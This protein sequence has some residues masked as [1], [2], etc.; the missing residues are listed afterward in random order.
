MKM[1][2]SERGFVVERQVESI[3]AIATSP[4]NGK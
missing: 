2:E 1:K 4:I 3:V